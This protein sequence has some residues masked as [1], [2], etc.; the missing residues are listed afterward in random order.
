MKIE[1]HDKRTNTFFVFTG[2]R[3]EVTI[4][5][6]YRPGEPDPRPAA[7]CRVAMSPVSEIE[8]IMG[9]LFDQI[10]KRRGEATMRAAYANDTSDPF[11]KKMG[12]D[13]LGSLSTA[14]V[15]ATD[16]LVMDLQATLNGR[17]PKHFRKAWP[18]LKPPKI[19]ENAALYFYE[20]S[21]PQLRRLAYKVVTDRARH[22]R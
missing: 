7:Y 14:L 16:D 1:W 11:V 19:S 2:G 20:E 6:T 3:N 18:K 21:T 10:A 15:Q 12:P 22:Y 9:D 17:P 13:P 5:T 8:K 4:I